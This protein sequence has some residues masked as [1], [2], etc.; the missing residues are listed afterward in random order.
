MARFPF[1]LFCLFGLAYIQAYI[2]H[3]EYRT[4][5]THAHEHD[6]ANQ[7]M[8]GGEGDVVYLRYVR[9]KGRRPKSRSSENAASRNKKGKKGGKWGKGCK[10]QPEPSPQGRETGDCMFLFSVACSLVGLSVL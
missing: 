9:D 1:P 10:E 4:Q 7:V 6:R 5:H 3:T 2:T 8:L